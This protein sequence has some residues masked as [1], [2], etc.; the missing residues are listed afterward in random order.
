[1]NPE[2]PSSSNYL[3]QIAPQATKK[4]V[5]GVKPRLIV[6]IGASLVVL[7]IIA[8]IGVAILNATRKQP[9]ETLVAR[10]DATE[11]IANSATGSIKSSQLR[12]LN[13][14]IRLFITNTNRD[15]QTPL[16]KVN[17]DQK[18]LPDSVTKTE[19]AEAILGRLEEARLNAI[20]DRAYAREMAYQLAL[21]LTALQQVYQSSSNP[22]TKAFLDNAYTSLET[23]H[24]TLSNYSASE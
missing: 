8:S 13:S 16:M 14:E 11:Q 15:I 23:T 7:V 19:S 20:Y 18:K 21:V 17:V 1:M 24:E 3:D 12:S 9:W 4:S 10:L 2:Q 22:E 6:V 5:L